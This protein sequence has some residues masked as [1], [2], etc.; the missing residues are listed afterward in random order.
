MCGLLGNVF[1]LIKGER[2][3]LVRRQ[4]EGDVRVIG[5][6]ISQHYF[7]EIAAAMSVSAKSN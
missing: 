1:A 3:D 6:N 7:A 2:G 5:G 4:A